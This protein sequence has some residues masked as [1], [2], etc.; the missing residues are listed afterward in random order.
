MSSGAKKEASS[1]FRSARIGMTP[2]PLSRN[3]LETAL[4]LVDEARDRALEIRETYPSIAE[5][6]TAA[7]MGVAESVI[8]IMESRLPGRPII[9]PKNS[10]GAGLAISR[11]TIASIETTNF[12]R[13]SIV[14]PPVTSFSAEPSHHE[15]GGSPT[16]M[17]SGASGPRAISSNSII[18]A[19]PKGS[20]SR[21]SCASAVE[22]Q[23]MM[24][25]TP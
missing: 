4:D 19:T 6:M 9:V 1:S 21:I 11:R 25:T 23:F 7:A 14:K 2:T 18:P 10:A 17:A 8:V 12:V 13:A 3:Q 5:A 22:A 16:S 15:R 20:F 24:K